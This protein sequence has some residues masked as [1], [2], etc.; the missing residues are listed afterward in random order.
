MADAKYTDY[1]GLQMT[2]TQG[3]VS[4]SIP[5]TNYLESG[6]EIENEDLPIPCGHGEATRGRMEK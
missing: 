1:G 6:I 4:Y 5:F 3:E 2:S